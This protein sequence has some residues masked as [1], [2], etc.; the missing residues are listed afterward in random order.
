MFP[1]YLHQTHHPIADFSGILSF[2]REQSKKPGLHLFPE[3]FLCGYPLQ[4][5]CLQASFI[6]SYQEL[7]QSIK[8]L[9][10][11]WPEEVT[12]LMGG[13][14]YEMLPEQIPSKIYNAI[15]ELKNNSFKP[16]YFKR[17]LP[18]YDI[19]DEQK[20]FTAGLESKLYLYQDKK[21]GLMI[22]EDMWPSS[23]HSIDPVIEMK[24]YSSSYDLIINLSAS[25]FHWNKQP[26]RIA[27]AKEISHYLR[28]P[29]LYLNRV[30]GEDEILFDGSSFLV[31]G[32]S[33]HLTAPSFKSFS[34]LINWPSEKAKYVDPSL[35]TEYTF[36][37]LLSPDW[38][39]L[40]NRQTRLKAWSDDDC[41]LIL[42]ALMFGL[43]EYA[44]KSNFKKFLIALSGGMD[45]A[46]VL[47]ITHLAIKKYGLEKVEAIYMPSIHS[48]SLSYDLSFALCEKLGI[49]LTSLPIKFLHSAIKNQFS[50]SF[51]EP[52]LGLTD[53]NVQSRLRGMLLYTRSNQN[54][55][56]VINTSNR[57]EI[58]VGYSTQYGDSV[59]AISLLG[60][61]YKSE[62]YRLAAY[63]N[64]EYQG[65][66]P[67][68][69]I[70]RAPSAELRDNQKDT[71]SLPAYEQL[72][73]ILEGILSYRS[74]QEELMKRG[75][76]PAEVSRVFDL[77]SRS[78]YKRAQFCPILKIKAK[79][80]GFGYRVPINKN[81]DFYRLK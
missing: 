68:E 74:D 33:T 5:L 37:S 36:E 45:S 64:Q 59:G 80:F 28:A 22:C 9:S 77:Y 78:E 55:S 41:Q 70:S 58:A 18:N 54:G 49:S 12:L 13:I 51:P 27:R 16:I 4:D 17:L 10:S 7:L 63:I 1:L 81:L 62:V 56:M 25:P 40:P 38:T 75:F 11:T 79:S 23:F 6:K 15:F 21:I 3:L 20:Y 48:S 67:Q 52:F 29:F 24:K 66:I 76:N 57:S 8:K 34:T 69:I 71:D 31:D 19:F 44:K 72:D 65:L 50:Q 73:A 2:L 26:K 46:L 53:E 14:H 60:D 32:D 35:K 43:T 61:L 47:V 42:E 30:G 39:T